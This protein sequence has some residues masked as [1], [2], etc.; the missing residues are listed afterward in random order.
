VTQGAAGGGGAGG[1]PPRKWRIIVCRGPECGVKRGSAA[2]ATAFA[3][4]AR[5]LGLENRIELTWQSCFGRCRQGPNVLVRLAPTA[6]ARSLLATLP[7]GP[8]QGAALYNDVHVDDVRRI[9]ES[10]VGRGIMV[11]E[12][13][14]RP[15]AA[16]VPRSTTAPGGTGA[17]PPPA[18]R[19][20]MPPATDDTTEAS[21]HATTPGPEST[22]DP[23]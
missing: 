11:R 5:E 2:L 8:G 7:A 10:H 9:L 15:D 6:P 19:A 4:A 21:E 1:G 23:K 22:G 3:A 16:V 14:L 12:L 17:P 13:I 18:D 20:A